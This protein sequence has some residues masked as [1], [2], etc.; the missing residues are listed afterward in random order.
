MWE[1]FLLVK[2]RIIF[3]YVILHILFINSPLGGHSVDF[4]ITMAF[5]KDT[6]MINKNNDLTFDILFCIIWENPQ[7]KCC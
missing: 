2:N 5:V 1:M 3:Y 6:L 4:F 7:E